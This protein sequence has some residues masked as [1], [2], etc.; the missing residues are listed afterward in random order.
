MRIAVSVDDMNHIAAHL[1]RCKI[2]HIYGKEGDHVELLEVIKT[3]GVH[4]D[5]II[6]EILDC[7]VVISG[8]IGEGMIRSL[9]KRKIRPY[10]E[11]D[12]IDPM[13]AVKKIY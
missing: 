8:Q 5:H 2:F 3:A 13:E 9:R 10:I 1:G 11:L 12:T 4:T 6:E 7:H